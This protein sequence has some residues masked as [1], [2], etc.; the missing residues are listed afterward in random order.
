MVLAKAPTV[1]F[2][3]PFPI[4]NSRIR[5]GTDQ[6]RRK[7][8]QATRKEPPPFDAAMR[9]NRQIFPVPTAMPSMARSIP[10]RELKTSDLDSTGCLLA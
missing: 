7:T 2:R 4:P 5:R 3:V 1:P 8:A 6:R 10:H 9:G